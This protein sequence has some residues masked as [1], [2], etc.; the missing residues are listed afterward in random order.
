M[1]LPKGYKEKRTFEK[2]I[3]LDSALIGIEDGFVRYMLNCLI[4]NGV[5]ITNIKGNLIAEFETEFTFFKD[6]PDLEYKVIGSKYDPIFQKT[7]FFVWASDNPTNENGWSFIFEYDV[8]SG[9]VNVVCDEY[10][11][12]ELNFEQ[13]ELITAIS[14][15]FIDNNIPLLYWAQR[16][17]LRKINVYKAKQTYAQTGGYP[18]LVLETIDRIK[19]PPDFAPEIVQ[20]TDTEFVGNNIQK[21]FFQFS[22]RNVFDDYEKSAPGEWS[23]VNIPFVPYGPPTDDYI[24]YQEGQRN[25]CIRI[26]LKKPFSTVTKLEIFAREKTSD[27]GLEINFD[28]VIYDTIKVADVV[29]DIN[30][31]Y[32]YKFYNDKVGKLVTQSDANKIQDNVPLAAVASAMAGNSRMMEGNVTEGFDQEPID[33]TVSFD[34]EEFDTA[35][36]EGQTN[37]YVYQSL[38]GFDRGSI[39]FPVDPSVLKVGMALQFVFK[40]VNVIPG[41]YD[42]KYILQESDFVNYPNNLMTN[43][44]IAWNQYNPSTDYFTMIYGG[45]LD[46]YT[47]YIENPYNPSVPDNDQ[48]ISAVVGFERNCLPQFKNRH[49]HY[50]GI[51]YMDEGQRRSPVQKIEKFYHSSDLFKVLTGRFTVNHIPPAWAKQWVVYYGG[52]DAANF[53]QTKCTAISAPD[54]NGNYTCTVDWLNTGYRYKDITFLKYE[55]SVGDRIKFYFGTNDGDLNSF[56]DIAVVSVNTDETIV[57]EGNS[58]LEKARATNSQFVVEIYKKSTFS[59]FYYTIAKNDIGDPG[60]STRYHKGNVQDQTDAPLPAIQTF[61]G[62]NTYIRPRYITSMEK[63]NTYTFD[64]A[65]F[66]NQFVGATFPDTDIIVKVWE[67]SGMTH[68]ILN[69]NFKALMA[70]AF[71]GDI[72]LASA[73]VA[74]MN[75]PSGAFITIVDTNYSVFWFV[76]NFL[77]TQPAFSTQAVITQN[78]DT[79]Q[80]YFSATFAESVPTPTF[81]SPLL[82]FAQDAAYSTVDTPD[83]QTIFNIEDPN[84]SDIFV[85]TTTGD[86]SSTSGSAVTSLGK[87]N[88]INE[89]FRRVV[90]ENTIWFSEQLIPESNLNGLSSFPDGQF[91]DYPQNFGSIQKFYA[92]DLDLIVFMELRVGKV[93]TNRYLTG[94][95]GANIVLNSDIVL[96]TMEFYAGL[97]GI[98]KHPE[99]HAYFGF[100][101]FYLDPVNGAVCRLSLDGITV[102]SDVKNAEGN[103]LVRQS[104]YNAI[105][106]ADGNFVGGFN[107]RRNCYEVNIGGVPMVWDEQKK[108]WIGGRSYDAEY[109]GNAGIDLV[110][111]YNGRLYLHEANT[112]RNNF[113]GVQYKSQ[114]WVPGNWKYGDGSGNVICPKKIYKAFSERSETIWDAFEVINDVGQ[115]TIV[116]KFRFSKREG[117]YYAALRRDMNT[118]NV[119]NPIVDGK[120]MRDNVILLKL[121][122]DSVEHEWFN[123]VVINQIESK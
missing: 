122:N 93:P 100:A 98:G 68:E 118:V 52:F 30:D 33:L 31:E 25:N 56:I 115:L 70:A 80:V 101:H 41:N 95:A 87:P 66:Y 20:V 75:D 27:V 5:D 6:N 71:Q 107:P 102:I 35:A 60:L 88:I 49:T 106:E 44:N 73:F 92:T 69:F 74:P 9:I 108:S 77:V 53:Y 55:Y 96:T 61:K 32:V 29:W 59:G 103:Y 79:P 8:A 112:L 113:Y 51:G 83:V 10:W 105:K 36:I 91:R 17:G 90:R 117:I 26:T 3:D 54:S 65:G 120:Q 34:E 18:D 63:T 81:N 84:Q 4:D 38:N 78:T 23:R 1:P 89:N 7:Y 12:D 19:Y 116:D 47:F 121:Q 2:G 22:V 82:V 64:T 39:V 43:I 67:D 123:N 40:S 72:A 86:A 28:W 11:S 104:L 14:I 85:G 58:W 94:G 76:L 46:G 119:L 24:L 109:F 13:D 114:V 50:F 16:A 110:S 42:F 15:N 21:A 97:Y 99:S 45:A 37:V 48:I 111:F 57:V 62:V